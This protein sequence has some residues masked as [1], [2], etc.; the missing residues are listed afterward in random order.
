[1]LAIISLP[2]LLK[3]DLN[4]SGLI[5]LLGA[6]SIE[7]FRYHAFFILVAAPYIA[8]G[9]VLPD[10]I[11][12]KLKISKIAAPDRMQPALTKAV[13]P[14][15]VLSLF[16]I[17][18]SSA[19]RPE[20]PI[21]KNRYPTAIVDYMQKQDVHGKVFN[22]FAWGG[23]LTWHLFP[24]V[25]IY[26]DGRVLDDIRW[27][28]YTHILWNTKQGLRWFNEAHFDYVLIPSHNLFSNEAYPLYS[29]LSANP[30]WQIIF[31]DINGSLFANMDAST[32]AQE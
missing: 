10:K 1:M 5:I 7:A 15:L 8:Q 29:Y 18:I 26:V 16:I 25:K 3:H 2:Y 27:A 23:Y 22:F 9:I 17:S 21:N 31:Q 12:A 28:K 30:K 13:L 24:E 6:L 14:A 11:K 20:E 4:K 19:P 32:P